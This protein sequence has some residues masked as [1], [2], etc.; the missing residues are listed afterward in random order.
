MAESWRIFEQLAQ[1]SISLSNRERFCP[2]GVDCSDLT[3]KTT[4]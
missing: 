1:L 3:K 2:Y 4:N